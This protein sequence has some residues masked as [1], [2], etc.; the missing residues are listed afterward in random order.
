M[1]S[2]ISIRDFTHGIRIL[3]TEEAPLSG[4]APD[5]KHNFSL[6]VAHPA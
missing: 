3:I 2:T 1:A 6:N 5:V 4:A